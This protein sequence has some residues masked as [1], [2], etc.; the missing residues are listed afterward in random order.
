MQGRGSVA[1]LARLAARVLAQYPLKLRRTDA[2]LVLKARPA[3]LAQEH[4]LI[5]D[6]HC[7]AE[8]HKR[9]RKSEETAKVRRK[10][11]KQREQR[12]EQSDRM[13]GRKRTDRKGEDRCIGKE[14]DR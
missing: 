11:K 14:E 9:G 6:V 2:L 7:K 5:A 13:T 10:T 3:I 4:L 12:E 8:T 1:V